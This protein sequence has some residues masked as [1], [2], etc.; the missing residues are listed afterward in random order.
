MKKKILY[1]IADIMDNPII[2]SLFTWIITPDIALSTNLS[3]YIGTSNTMAE[4]G[5][6][7]S[8]N[9]LYYID[10]SVRLLVFALMPLMPIPSGHRT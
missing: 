5:L 9:Q 8:V 3:A 2:L 4:F 10:H 6:D 7:P 1:G